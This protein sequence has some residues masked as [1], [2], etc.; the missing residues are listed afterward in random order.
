MIKLEKYWWLS[1]ATKIQVWKNK[2]NSELKSEIKK[3][4]SFVVFT[5]KTENQQ[6]WKHDLYTWAPYN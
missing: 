3:N 1:F 2:H 6:H 4:S 5:D